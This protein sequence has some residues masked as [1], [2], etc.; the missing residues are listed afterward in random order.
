MGFP[1]VLQIEPASGDPLAFVGTFI[2]LSILF[3]VT[4]HIA[5]RYVLGDVPVTRALL[6]GPVPAGITLLLQEYSPAIMLLVG[7][8][9]DWLV[10][11]RVYQ[12]QPRQVFLITAVHY[13]VSVLLSLSIASLLALLGTAPI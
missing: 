7:L 1:A 5:A 11:W 3:A 12:V 6:V 4:A 9:G 10:I 13:A 2:L 8:T